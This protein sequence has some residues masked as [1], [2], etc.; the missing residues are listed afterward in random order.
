MKKILLTIVCLLGIGLVN[1]QTVTLD[2]TTNSWGLPETKDNIAKEAANFTNGEYTIQLEAA[3]NGYYFNADGYLLFGKK[4]ATLTLPVF[5]FD[6]KRIEVIG[7]EGASGSTLENIYVGDVAVSTE[8]KGATGT[9][10]FDIAAEYQAAGNVYVLKINSTHNA[11]VTYIK[12]YSTSDNVEDNP[13]EGDDPIEENNAV[14]NAVTSVEQ[15]KAGRVIIAADNLAATGLGDKNYGYLNTI[16]VTVNAEGN[17]ET[18]ANNA[19]ELEAVEGGYAIKDNYGKYVYMKGTYNSFNVSEST[20]TEGGVWSITFNEAGEATIMNVEK[21]KYIQYSTGYTSFGSYAEAQEGGILPKIY[22]KEEKADEIVVSVPTFS[23]EKGI[24]AEAIS[25]ELKTETAG[26]EIYYT[27]DGSDPTIESTKYTGAINVEKTTT[28]K[29][30]AAYTAN[31]AVT[32]SNV[33]SAEYIISSVKTYKEVSAITSGKQYILVSKADNILGKPV[34]SNKKYNYLYKE[35]VT[36][37]EGEIK[38]NDHFAFTIEAVEG[39]YTIKD[40]YGRYLYT[41]DDTYKNFNVSETMPEEGAVWTITFNEAGEATITNVLSGKY[42]QY[43]AQYNSYGAYPDA[44]GTLPTLYEE[45]DDTSI[46]YI[47]NNKEDIVYDLLGRR[48]TT[49]TRGIYIVNG[50]KVIFD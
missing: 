50:K 41:K 11:Q 38:T 45:A 10:A 34:E 13:G 26:A 40:S 24:Y 27:T 25:V 12:V 36:I 33:V 1:A 21:S 5:S 18:A 35:E 44:Q 14:F 28:I 49:P 32:Y 42:I 46:E 30:I 23:I 47:K 43:S 19:F 2:F 3:T 20:P 6:V 7:R 4:N 17:V 29:A 37:A 22:L 8:C 48:I 9:N 16:T 31:N 15:L 39:G